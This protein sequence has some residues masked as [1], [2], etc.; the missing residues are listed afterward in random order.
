MQKQSRRNLLKNAVTAAAAV[1]GA[2]AVSAKAGAA[3]ASGKLEKKSYSG[4]VN[5]D[6]AKAEVPL[7]S[8]AVSYGNLLFLA[9]VGAHFK[10]TIE[11]HTKH[12]LDELE[13]NLVA[14]GSSMEKVLK[15]NVYLNDIN[16]WAKMNTVYAGRWG[17]IPPVR[18]TVAPAGGIPGNSLVEIDL[19][20]YI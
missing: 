10:G 5:T 18:T 15:V 4:K 16:D 13:K 3:Q 2:A 9:G 7:F 20:A 19:I 8:S 14:A 6:N 12:V 1:T 11:E 17:K